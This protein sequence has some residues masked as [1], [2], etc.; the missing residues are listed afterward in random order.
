M[1]SKLQETRAEV[2]SAQA[3]LAALRTEFC[4]ANKA[5]AQ[6]VLR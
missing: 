4:A 3:Q 2:D 6:Q 5:E 1:D